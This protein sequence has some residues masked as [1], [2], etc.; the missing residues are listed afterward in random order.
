MPEI[1]KRE[2]FWRSDIRQHTFMSQLVGAVVSEMPSGV[3][4]RLSQLLCL[5]SVLSGKS[6]SVRGAEDRALRR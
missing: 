5:R 6:E 2:A 3:L 4:W 1:V